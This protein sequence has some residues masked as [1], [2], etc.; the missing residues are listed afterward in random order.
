LKEEGVSNLVVSELDYSQLL[1]T[2]GIE[3]KDIWL[4]LLKE[5][6]EKADAF[7]IKELTESFEIILDR[8]TIKELLDDSETGEVINNFFIYLKEKNK[9]KF[10]ECTRAFARFILRSKEAAV[11]INIDKLK[12]IFAAISANDYSKI[13]FDELQNFK[14][15]DILGFTLF[16]K[17]IDRKKYDEIAEA[18][19]QRMEQDQWLKNNPQT[20]AKIKELFL[21][22]ENVYM[23][24]IYQRSLS[25]MLRN[26]S[27]S[28]GVSFDSEQLNGNFSLVLLDL[29]LSVSNKDRLGSI[30]ENMLIELKAALAKNDMIYINNFITAIEIKQKWPL[31]PE[32]VNLRIAETV[33]KFIFEKYNTF[34]L[35]CF[36]G[37]LKKSTYDVQTY[38]I[39]IFKEKR[40]NSCIIQMFFKFFPGNISLFYENIDKRVLNVSFISRI[41]Q[42]LGGLG[43]PLALSIIKHIFYLGNSLVKIEAL[44]A[45]QS[46][47]LYDEEFLFLILKNKDF[48]QRKYAFFA[49]LGNVQLHEKLAHSLL[50]ITN[51]FGVRT[52]IIIDNLKLIKERPFDEAKT[53]LEI[54]G[55]YRFLWNRSVRNKAKEILRQY[56][57][58]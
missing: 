8:L 14:G 19:I 13:L 37:I 40:I 46:L 7:R 30:L 58:Q 29:F 17:F 38:L 39:K 51:P 20:V 49:L 1:E 23:S 48:L 52:G 12:V 10:L 27:F 26:I 47:G 33:E 50:S 35:R 25:R 44:K 45:M 21:S 18:L 43:A 11:G 54:L 16:S 9:E 2:E 3:Y 36:M 6:I 53:Y 57:R 34:D 31:F 15:I 4:Y 55:K 41:I 56:E 5:S 32:E 28:G 22:S 42:S 24:D